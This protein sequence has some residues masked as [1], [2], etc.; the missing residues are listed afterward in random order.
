MFLVPIC[1]EAEL[2]V[3]ASVVSTAALGQSGSVDQLMKVWVEEMGS[4]VAYVL[5]LHLSY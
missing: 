5:P 4:Y 2:E 1:V 3:C